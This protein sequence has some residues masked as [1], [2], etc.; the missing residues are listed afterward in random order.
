M[1]HTQAKITY[2]VSQEKTS[3]YNFAKCLPIFKIL[4]LT[5]T[6]VNMKQNRH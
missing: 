1:E 6:I 2:T 4:S 5:D 3:H